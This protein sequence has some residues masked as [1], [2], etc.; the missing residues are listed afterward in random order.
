MIDFLKQHSLQITWLLGI[1]IPA[2]FLYLFIDKGSK[3]LINKASAKG[4]EDFS[5][6]VLI[7]RI[8]KIFIILFVLLFLAY[9][10]VEKSNYAFITDNIKTIAW[11]AF[12]SVFTIISIKFSNTI[13]NRTIK[14]K[15]KEKENP[16]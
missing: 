5:F 11:L 13:F 10:F 1:L 15:I 6:I 2:V 16:T 14:K 8:L 4:Y 9:F 7:R 12:V 3:K